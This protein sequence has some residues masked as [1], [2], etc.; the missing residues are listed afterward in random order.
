MKRR[1]PLAFSTTS[2]LLLTLVFSNAVPAVHATPPRPLNFIDTSTGFNETSAR[3]ADGNIV[4]TNTFTGYTT[5]DLNVTYEGAAHWVIFKNGSAV[6]L[7]SSTITGT[8]FGSSVGTCNFS[9]T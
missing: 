4:G 7:G 9:F 2:I 6:F 1:I 5:G 8:L 3:S